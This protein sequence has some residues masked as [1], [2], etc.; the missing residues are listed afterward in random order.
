MVNFILVKRIFVINVE[1]N[2]AGWYN[3]KKKEKS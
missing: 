2:K 1:L 3:G